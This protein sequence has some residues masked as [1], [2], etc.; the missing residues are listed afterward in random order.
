MN[1][2][3]LLLK[4]NDL[5]TRFGEDFKSPV[6]IMSLAHSIDNLT[7]VLYPMGEHLSGMCIK[8][9]DNPVIA[10]NSGMSMGRQHFSMAH[11]LFHLYYDKSTTSICSKKIGYGKEIEKQADQFASYFLIPP[12]ALK[13][14]I[15]QLKIDRER[16]LS[17]EDIVKIEQYFMVSRQ[18][19]LFRLIEDNEISIHDVEEMKQN[20]IQS[21][22]CF[23][24]SDTLYKPLPELKQYMTYGYL[25][26][27]TNEAYK[28]KLISTGKYN[29]ILLSAFRADIVYGTE[30]EEEEIVD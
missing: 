26:K 6:D 4:A 9:N 11:E 1:K 28:S 10:I 5:R 14:K 16:T 12:N 17:I 15:K 29:E 25:I 7:I 20:V 30:E 3:D 19:I 27:Q 2:M 21:A 8:S 13:D 23:G 24:Y 22:T 18:A